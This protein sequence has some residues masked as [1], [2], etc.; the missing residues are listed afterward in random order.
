[1]S[2][3]TE[4]PVRVA[5]SRSLA[6]EYALVLATAGIEG[7]LEPDG[8]GWVVLVPSAL[9]ERAEATLAAYDADATRAD[10]DAEPPRTAAALVLSAVILGVYALTG[11]RL[12]WRPAFRAGSAIAE[13][14]VAGEWWRAVTALT[15]HADE[16]HLLGNAFIGL[17]FTTPVCRF[18]GPG[19][20]PALILATGVV[21]NVL[22]ALVRG[23]ASSSVGASTALFG[24]VGILCGRAAV[25]A[26]RRRLPGRR[27]WMPL[28]AGIALLALLGTSERADLLAH[29]TGFMV[30]LPLGAWT[31]RTP[32]P[33]SRAQVPLALGSAALVA[34]SWVLAL[35]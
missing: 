13:R 8:G 17:I 16:A 15:L 28:G 3:E 20:G 14:M 9:A 10:D 4:S 26:A 1:M 22:A 33:G 19:L 35:R 30:G 23:T 27:P 29:F 32:R 12:A 31:A 2:D 6:D 24:T 7:R 25:R 21:G 34:G 11:P 5:E 18:L